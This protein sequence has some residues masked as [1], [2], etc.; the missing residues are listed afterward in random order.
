MQLSKLALITCFSLSDWSHKW[1]CQDTN[2]IYPFVCVFFFPLFFTPSHTFSFLSLFLSLFLH[3]RSNFLSECN[4]QCVRRSEK[5]WKN[6]VSL[7]TS[8]CI[9]EMFFWALILSLS[10]FVSVCLVMHVHS[11]SL[12]L[13]QISFCQPL[14]WLLVWMLSLQSHLS[15]YKHCWVRPDGTLTVR[16]AKSVW[17]LAEWCRVCTSV[18]LLLGKRKR[19]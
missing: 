1:P 18:H 2:C 19:Q 11:L 13:S 17:P 7:F 5:K 16:D 9:V 14:Q 10:L 6:G 12:C 3:T 4:K 15:T 8:I